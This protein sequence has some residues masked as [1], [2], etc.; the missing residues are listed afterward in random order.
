VLHALHLILFDLTTL[1]IFGE[2]YKL[3]SSSLCCLCEVTKKT[4]VKA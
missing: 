4:F 2:V 1:I 3:W